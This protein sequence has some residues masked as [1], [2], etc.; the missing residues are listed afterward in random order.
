MAG[1]FN[2]LKPEIECKILD[3]RFLRENVMYEKIVGPKNFNS[4]FSYVY[5]DMLSLVNTYFKILGI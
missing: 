1:T 5:I 3:K 2:I 4:Y